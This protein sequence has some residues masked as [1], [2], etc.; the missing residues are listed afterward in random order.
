MN[1][2]EQR[3]KTLENKVEILEKTLETLKNMG[4]SVSDNK[5]LD[6]DKERET[7]EIVRNA[8]R[9]IN[10]QISRA[11]ENAGLFSEEYPDDSRY[12]NYEIEN[13]REYDG[14]NVNVPELAPYIG[15]GIR[16]TSYNGFENERVIVPKEIDGKPVISIGVEAFM[17]TN[18]SQ[19]ILPS[20]LKGILASAFKGCKNLT[21]IDLPYGL[22]YLGPSCFSSTAL[23]SIT[24]PDTVT[25]LSEK[26]F[27]G[28]NN[29]EKVL[30]GNNITEIESDA[31]TFCGKLTSIS[32]PDSLQSIGS[33][34]FSCTK[35]Q[36]ISLPDSLQNIGHQAF[37][38]TEIQTIILP[39]N[40]KKISDDAFECC[41]KNH[42][43]YVFLG[44]DTKVVSGFSICY[45]FKCDL[46]YCLPGSNIQKYAQ[47]RR[48]PIKP[49]SEFKIEDY[50]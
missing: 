2:F 45:E 35:I 10:E 9:N 50:Q 42:I 6:F 41:S 39:E 7:V 48:I 17:N 40:L 15:K 18:L 13:G 20:T 28:C 38:G 11:I 31:F 3:L 33:G 44:M 19:I 24:I 22:E 27:S 29:L 12:F 32:L 5:K 46:I 16:I 30:L 37:L 25:S 34:A 26:C 8:K 14:I 1:D 4:I 43:T 49:L 23:S 36:T 21:H 47:E